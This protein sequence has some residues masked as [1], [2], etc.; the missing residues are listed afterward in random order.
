MDK[1]ADELVDRA[2]ELRKNNNY[3]GSLVAARSALSLDSDSSD[4][5]WLIA[6]NNE[7]LGNHSIALDAFERSLELY[8]DNAYRWARFGQALKAAGQSETAIDAFNTALKADSTQEQ[9]LEGLVSFYCWDEK[10]KDDDLGF[11]CLKNLDD[12][13]GLNLDNDINKLGAY[14]YSKGLYLDSLRCFKR[15]INY[16]DFSHGHFNTG[17][18]YLALGQV[19]DAL[20]I[21][22]EGKRFYPDYE[23]QKTEFEKALLGFNQDVAK[24]SGKTVIVDAKD[25]FT[26][27]VNPFELLNIDSSEDIEEVDARY[28]KRQKNLLLQEIDL[29]DGRLSWLAD[30]NI[31]KSKA[32]G[33][34]DELNNEKLNEYHK[35][36]FQN[37]LVLNFLS[38]G[39]IS[40]FLA[41]PNDD[42]E[43]FKDS[44]YDS[45]FEEWFSGYF[46]RQF[47]AVFK[48]IFK[49]KDLNAYKIILQGRHWVNDAHLNLLFVNSFADLD[50][51]LVGLRQ[52]RGLS[53]KN[54]YT[55]AKVLEVIND[56]WVKAWLSPLPVQFV[57]L[58]EEA[59]KLIR[60]IAVDAYMVHDDSVT[61][62]AILDLAKLFVPKGS[63]LKF[64]LL[65]DTKKI[66][67]IIA[68]E[69]KDESSVTVGGIAASIK[70]T[71]ISYDKQFIP[72]SKVDSLCWGYSVTN[73]NQSLSYLYQFS[74]S[75]NGQSIKMVWGGSKE[76]DRS[77][78][79]YDKHVKAIFSYIFSY[80]LKNIQ[81]KLDT[82][83]SVVIGSC[84]LTAAGVQY[85]TKGWFS[86]KTHN[87]SW[88]KLKVDLS[89]GDLILFSIDRP[90]EKITMPLKDTQNSFILF[91]L[92]R[93]FEG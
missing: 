89:N 44:L 30:I 38:R 41:E 65:E 22:F 55:A 76:N 29:E 26:N 83:R 19:T 66:S 8:E 59:A 50:N 80:T 37:K 72:A 40:F 9:A 92:V 84:T 51:L 46:A 24:L 4:A 60:G 69:L 85:V 54:P 27:Y 73:V 52:A 74:F 58:Q 93:N 31:D 48:L 7:S 13:H 57:E 14:Y 43:A 49:S 3:E 87:V 63:S 16:S 35:L 62:K 28:I 36:I 34:V 64:D 81:E 86:N 6:L 39:D 18:S 17:L 21:W 78:E 90:S 77:K 25:W 23:V 32:I 10:H 82:G 75:G 68:D 91:S 70:R 56:P 45:D 5:W 71:G 88:S 11:E 61:S 2:F 15:V 12:N 79:F 47:D 42:L 67:E 33:I 1:S 53:K 20:D